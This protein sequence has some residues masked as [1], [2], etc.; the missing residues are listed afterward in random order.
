M[1]NRPAL[2]SDGEDLLSAA[3]SDHEEGADGGVASGDVEPL[4]GHSISPSYPPEARPARIS[5]MAEVLSLPAAWLDRL[6]SLP[7]DLPLD[8]GEEE[9]VQ[10]LVSAIAA[11]VPDVRVAIRLPREGTPL[12]LAVE[13]RHVLWSEPPRSDERVRSA[14][15]FPETAYE[16]SVALLGPTA[17]GALH[18]ASEQD[19]LSS[20][21]SPH[22]QLMDRASAVVAR[23]LTG[24]RVHD[25]A[26]ALES[27]L[28][29]T[30]A[31]MV[32]AE[33]LASL[34]QIAAGMVHELNNPLTSI[35]AYT[36]FLLR[37]A[38]QRE[39]SDPDDVER[40]RRIA[41]SANRMLRLTRDLVS[42]ARPSGDIPIAVQL[43]VVIERALAFCEHEMADVGVVVER[44]FDEDIGLVRGL[45]EQLAQVFVNLVTNACHAMAK[46]QD[47]AAPRREPGS[48]SEGASS[49]DT[50]AERRPVLLVST[51]RLADGSPDC[52]DGT[53]RVAVVVQDAGHGIRPEHLA[54][55][56]NPF[57]TTKGAGRGTG[58]GLS[59]V[60]N[61]VDGHHG[62][63]R[64][65]S[66]PSFGTRF[67]LVFPIEPGSMESASGVHPSKL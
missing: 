50:L 39:G 47:T 51:A 20:D 5:A 31:Q 52:R 49:D 14:R 41:E 65:E 18:F 24:R 58:L 3:G 12:P 29:A 40:L 56:F 23:A 6:L 46:L 35:A 13:P 21:G 60:K 2:A 26:E 4:D 48:P 33:K 64:V 8:R 61:I 22:V 32:Q 17:R 25:R 67:I 34:G 30:R 9:L 43:N 37:R 1:S 45:P 62:K 59:I 38:V 11:I 66:D 36:D 53:P 16:R 19:V 54:L 44:S 27:E 7:L 55:V 15:V 63:I 57:F 42:Y 28:R 10:A